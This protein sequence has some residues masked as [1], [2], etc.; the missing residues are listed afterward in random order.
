MAH[1]QSRHSPATSSL[2]TEHRAS[3]AQP[4]ADAH[5]SEL[6][7]KRGAGN[8]LHLLAEDE[9]KS[10][11]NEGDV[12][13]KTFLPGCL[14]HTAEVVQRIDRSYTDMQ[15]QTVLEHECHLSKDFPAIHSSGFDDHAT[16]MDFAKFLAEARHDE[17]ADGSTKGYKKFCQNFFEHKGG[18]IPGLSEE[19]ETAKNRLSMAWQAIYI[20]LALVPVVLIALGCVLYRKRQASSNLQ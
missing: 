12:D 7:M 20:M 4:L 3:G 18:S 15:I 11:N 19:G 10:K 16:C 13:F 17:L 6:A 9:E 2:Q 8:L 5:A 14:V 1:R